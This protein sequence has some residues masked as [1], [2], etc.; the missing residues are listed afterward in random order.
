[1][2]NGETTS[3]ETQAFIGR[4]QEILFLNRWLAD[5]DAPAV[6]Y[7]H[8]AL[9]DQEKKGGIGKTWLLR[10]FYELVESTPERTTLPVAIDFFNATSAFWCVTRPK[11]RKSNAPT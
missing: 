1:M 3:T 9:K 7:I 10:R 8:D 6:V 2:K 4:E 11:V 5:G